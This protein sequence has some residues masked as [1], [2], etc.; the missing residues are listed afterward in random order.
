[1]IILSGNCRRRW[2]ESQQGFT[3][4]I[5]GYWRFTSCFATPLFAGNI[6]FVNFVHEWGVIFVNILYVDRIFCHWL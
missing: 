5:G 4:S 1:M 2:T 6:L 3:G